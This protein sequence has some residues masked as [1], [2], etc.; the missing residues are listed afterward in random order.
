VASDELLLTHPDP[1]AS[2][3]VH[4]AVDGARL[5]RRSWKG[6]GKQRHS[7][8]EFPD[9]QAARDGLEREVAARMREGFVFVRDPADTPVGQLVL[10]CASPNRDGPQTFD[11]H[12]EGHTL[13]VGSLHRDAYGADLH[14]IDVTTGQ[15]RLVHTEP[16]GSEPARQTFIHAVLFD[17]DGTGLIYALNGETR[18]LDLASGATRILASYEQFSSARF[19]PFCVRP[20]Q[21]AARRRM[22]LFDADDQVRIRDTSTDDDVFAMI[23]ADQPE[24]RAGA[25][26]PSGQLLAL[27]YG[28]HDAT[29][30]LWNVDSGRLH[31]LTGHT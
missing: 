1:P 15:R 14:L 24:C 27:A 11:L 16:P 12:P 6:A 8:R 22:V 25:L 21:D 19:N 26:S 7:S 3:Y 13:A 5:L 10:R 20:T 2:R 30:Q 4:L 18:H 28:V 23:V 17:A 29:V 31:R 9:P